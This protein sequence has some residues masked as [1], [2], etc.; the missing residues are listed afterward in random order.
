MTARIVLV[1]HAE[2]SKSARG[3]AI[4]RT[5][6]GLSREGAKH[7]RK[8]ATT[9]AAD[10][11]VSSPAKRARN[12]AAPIARANVVDLEIDDDLRE[13]DFG[14]FDGRTFASLERDHPD[15][16]ATWMRSPTTVLFPD[17]ETWPQLQERSTAA[18]EHLARAGEGRTTIGVT[19]L[20]VILA[21]LGRVLDVP[22]EEVFGITVLH[23]RS[24][25]FV[26]EAGSWV[27]EPP[28]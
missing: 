8:L 12:T 1:R 27:V 24:H 20:G 25:A 28:A 15:L 19:H 17:G 10:R 6:V 22:D 7:A 4:G 11:V 23:G 14:A 26:V 21:T 9:L 16:Y 5:D 18:L 2:P 13:I 3:R